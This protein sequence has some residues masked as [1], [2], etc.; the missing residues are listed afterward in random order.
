MLS[1]NT[2]VIN[3]VRI[4]IHSMIS[5]C[6]TTV[7]K[8]IRSLLL[9]LIGSLLLVGCQQEQ[10]A[11][12][13]IQETG[14]LR[15]GLDPTYP[16]FESLSGE[17]VE[18]IDVDLTGA[19]T[20]LMGL[21]VDYVYFGYD[22]LYD[23]LAT[24]QVDV[25]AS[26][27]VIVPSRLRDFKYSRTYFDAGQVLI[28][29]I[30]A[31]INDPGDLEGKVLAVELGAQ[32]HAEALVW[33]RRYKGLDIVPYQSANEAILAVKSLEVD[34]AV[35]DHV[36]A[37]LTAG[38]NVD[39]ILISEPITEEPYAL[40]VNSGEDELLKAINSALIK[41]EESRETQAILDRWFGQ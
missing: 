28:S 34:S 39:G 35:V 25:L 36:S 18:G 4:N 20:R 6:I 8:M 29:R 37:R 9:L 11:W 3:A 38:L 22:G 30:D 31:P 13:R 24:D 5:N 21:S 32:G 12:D 7:I 14:V 40:V 33:Q 17:N 26:A 19:I 1:R 2:P 16:P 27:L 23:A 41:L 10:N 15:V